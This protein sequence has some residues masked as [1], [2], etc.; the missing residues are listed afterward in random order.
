MNNI[1]RIAGYV[2]MLLSPVTIVFLLMAF[3]KIADKANAK[4][5]S[6]TTEIVKQSETAARNNL[7]LQWGI[8]F[9]IFIPIMVGLC[10]FGYYATKGEYNLQ[11]N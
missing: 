11:E 5:A 2:W 7:F 6:A 10:L 4:V 1:K 9:I 3:L 8:V